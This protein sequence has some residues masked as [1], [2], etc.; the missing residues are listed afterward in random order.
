MG[1]EDRNHHILKPK[2]LPANTDSVFVCGSVF[3]GI[4]RHLRDNPLVA[5]I[6]SVEHEGVKLERKPTPVHIRA[7]EEKDGPVTVVVGTKTFRHVLDLTPDGEISRRVN[8][9]NFKPG[10]KP[11]I[12]TL[13]SD[14]ALRLLDDIARGFLPRLDDASS[15]CAEK[16]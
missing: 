5:G 7:A 1:V 16:I 9:A 14:R 3:D 13:T 11:K 2:G 10:E 8:I 4:M 6:C 15:N 12:S